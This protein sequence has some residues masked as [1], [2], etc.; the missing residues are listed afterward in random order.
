MITVRRIEPGSRG[1]RDFV[2]VAHRV[3][4]QDPAWVPPLDLD[5]KMRLDPK[6]NPFFQHAEVVLFVAERDGELVGRV[7]AQVDQEH[8]ARYDDG[9]GFFGYLDTVDDPAVARALLDAAAAWLRERG[10]KRMRGPMSLNINE[11]MGVLVDGFDTPPMVMMPHHQPYQ[12]GLV[13]AA[14]LTK[15]KDV[16]AWAYKIGAVSARVRRA[17]DEVVKMPEVRAR[18]FDLSNLARDVKSALEI[19]NDAW[20]DNWG[21]LPMTPAEAQKL[22]EDLRVIMDPKLTVLVEI[23]G[24]PAAMAIALPNVNECIRDLDGKLFPAFTPVGL[25]KL[26]WRLKVERPRSGRLA[27]LGIKTKYRMVRKYAGLSLFLYTQMND[28]ARDRGMTRGELSWT[29][30]DNGKVNAGI[31]VM[32]GEIYKRYRVYER[33]L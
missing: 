30:E 29:L 15:V 25:V 1:V 13:E 18:E 10:M 9:A 32:G 19:F 2:A 6:Q 27:L 16:Y 24:E 12:G 8:I 22:A 20:K 23:D 5:M 4:R 11:E 7:T 17:H 21:F 28:R 26:L 31:R 14:G 3:H 33:A